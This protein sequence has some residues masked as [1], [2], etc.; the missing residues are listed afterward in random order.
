MHAGEFLGILQQTLHLGLRAAIAQLEV[1]QHGVILL[2]KPLIGVLDVLHGGAHLVGVVGHV[3]HSHV[4][5]IGSRLGVLAHAGQQAGGKAGGLLHVVVGRQAHGLVG[6]GSVGLNGV[7]AVLEQRF[8]TA[9][10]LLQRAAQVDGFRD[11]LADAGSRD[12]LFQGAHQLGTEGLSGGVTGCRRLPAQ[13]FGDLAL[14][15]LCRGHDLHI[16]FCQLNAVRHG[17]PPPFR[18]ARAA[19][20]SS[21]LS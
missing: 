8:H 2:G 14:D 13:G 19:S 18:A 7:G 1:V 5:Q 15:A 16:R 3:H 10:A 12:H 11:D 20:N 4:G 17:H 21:G 6:L 9:Q